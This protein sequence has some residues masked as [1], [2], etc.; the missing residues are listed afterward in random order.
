MDGDEDEIFDSDTVQTL[1]YATDV[2]LKGMFLKLR[3]L[4]ER[5]S[6]GVCCV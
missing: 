5:E 2:F 3:G 6:F 4:S 1:F